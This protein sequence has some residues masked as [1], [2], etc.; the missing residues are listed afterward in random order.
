[1]K[2]LSQIGTLDDALAKKAIKTIISGYMSPAFGSVTKRDFD[3]LMFMQLQELGLI[4]QNPEIYE[5][6]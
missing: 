3:I 5:L 4:E 6:Y 1:M 2:I